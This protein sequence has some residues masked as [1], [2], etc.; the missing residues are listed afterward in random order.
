M[1]IAAVVGSPRGLDGYTGPL[2]TGVLDAV[3]S[4]GAETQVLS[5]KDLTVN[6]CKGCLEICNVT[7]TCHQ[8]DDLET[9]KNSLL[10]ADGIIFATPAYFFSVSAQLKAVIDRLNLVYHCQMLKDKYSAMVVTCG[11]SDPED[12]TGYLGRVLT[13]FGFWNVGS[14][15]AVQVQLEDAD[16]RAKLLEEAKVLGNRMVAAIR[17]KQTFPEQEEDHAQAFEILKFM[18][19]TLR[20]QWKYPWDYWNTHF[21]LEE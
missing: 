15:C 18:V 9:V 2:V 4:A 20:D 13:Q 3:R 14:L 6:P 12:V 11:G 19:M 21:D 8:K 1:K 16:E 7:G 5:L 10:D 17:D